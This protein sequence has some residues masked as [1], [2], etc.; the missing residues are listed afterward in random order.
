MG[1]R[2]EKGYLEK[3]KSS[4]KKANGMRRCSAWKKSSG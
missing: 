2:T 3:L 4:A 1:K